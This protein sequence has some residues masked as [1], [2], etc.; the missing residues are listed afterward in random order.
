MYI[1]YHTAT[2]L[3]RVTPLTYRIP[4]ADLCFWSTVL[5][6]R[7]ENKAP[8]FPL[9]LDDIVFEPVVFEV[10]IRFMYTDQYIYRPRRFTLSDGV[11][12]VYKVWVMAHRLGGACN[13]LRNKCMEQVIADI[14]PYSYDPLKLRERP[15]DG[16]TQFVPMPHDVEWVIENVEC[17]APLPQL[18]VAV[19][20]QNEYQHITQSFP[21]TAVLSRCTHLNVILSERKLQ[22]EQGARSAN[23]PTDWAS[24]L[25]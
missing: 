23:L 9:F 12:M 2:T 14:A 8:H 5:V 17:S 24:Y 22:I 11:A 10:L 19:L 25:G 3:V 4:T 18:L 21:W 1:E 13:T 20:M 7:L 6:T 16:V 15:F